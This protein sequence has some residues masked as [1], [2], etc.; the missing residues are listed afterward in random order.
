MAALSQRSVIVVG[1]GAFGTST[2]YHLAQRGY[3]SVTVLDR[4]APPSLEAAAT[5]INKVIRADYPDPLYARLATE[6]TEKWSDPNGLFRGLYHRTGWL[7]AASDS[8]VAWIEQTVE[9]AA[10]LGFPR[11]QAISGDSVRSQ[12]PAFTG[13]LNDWKTYWNKSGG[14]ANADVAVSRMAEEAQKAGVRYVWGSA[15]YGKKLLFD[16]HG[17][18]IGVG[19][20]DGSAHFADL[21][22]LAA[23]AAAPSLLDFKGQL[24]AKGHTVGHVQLTAAE[25]ERY[26]DIPIVDHLEGGKY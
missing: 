18:C 22:V 24:V 4:W 14:W 10:K 16:E 3:N 21:V 2:A 19:C 9:T 15:G 8:S 6:A 1:A 7:L 5:D 11:A 17:A 23:G 12:W 20:A 26:K 13:A 25:V